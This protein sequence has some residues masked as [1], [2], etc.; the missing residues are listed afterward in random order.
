MC[1][2]K[3]PKSQKQQNSG[4]HA[5]WWLRDVGLRVQISSFKKSKFCGSNAQHGN[6]TVLYTWKL[7]IEQ[8]LNVLA[9]KKKQ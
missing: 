4:Y 2:L 5:W 1:N 7:L 8:N 3:K 9:T 6:N